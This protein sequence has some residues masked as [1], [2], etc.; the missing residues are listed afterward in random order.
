MVPDKPEYKRVDTSQ[1]DSQASTRG[2]LSPEEASRKLRAAFGHFPSGVTV[3]SYSHQGRAYGVTVSS[4]TPISL[5]PPLILVS[6]MRSGRAAD[7]LPHVPFAV[8]VLASDQFDVAFQFAGLSSSPIEVEWDMSSSAPRLTYAHAYFTC[9]P[10]RTYDGGD[11]VLVL[12]EVLDYRSTPD[13]HPLIVHRG[14][15]QSMA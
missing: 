4:F 15:W 12:G 9:R 14:A 8:N 10:W 5:E 2:R 6:L 1:F 7:L 11:H 13:T 3:V